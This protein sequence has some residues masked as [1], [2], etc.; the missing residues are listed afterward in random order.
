M[1]IKPSGAH[2]VGLSIV[3]HTVGWLRCCPI[4]G[5]I[6]ARVCFNLA[7]HGRI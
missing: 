5:R 4:A 7:R 1:N 2:I 6:P 3:I